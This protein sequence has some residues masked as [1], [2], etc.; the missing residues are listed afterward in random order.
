[1]SIQ[2]ALRVGPVAR[3]SVGLVALVVS[4]FVAMDLL[5]GVIPDR[6]SAQRQTRQRFAETLTVQVASLIEAGDERTLNRTLQQVVSRSP[7]VLS[8]AVRPVQGFIV[9][10]RGDHARN[11]ISPESGRSTLDHVRVP[12][13]GQRERW[14]DV[15]FAFAH[16]SP[17]GFQE[18][19]GDPKLLLVGA[20]SVGGFLLFYPY[21]RRALHFLDPS[22]AVPDRVRGA[23]DALSAGVIVVDSGGRIVLAN[24]SV[25]R[26]HPEGGAELHGS[27]FSELPWLRAAEKGDPNA[28]I[29]WDRAFRE[30]KAVPRHSLSIA[31]PDNQNIEVI[32]GC[33]PIGDDKG[34]VRGSLVTFDDVT[35]IYRTNEQLRSTLVDLERSREKIQAQNEELQRLAT[36]DPLTGC[37]NRRAFFENAGI[38]FEDR[39]RTNQDLSCIMADIDHFKNFNDLYGHAV[40]DQVI[41]VV[42]RT[43]SRLMRAQ[44]L[45]CRY[46][47]EEFCIVLPDADLKQAAEI[48]ERLRSTIE[49]GA[50]SAIRSTRV[51]R[52]TSSFG[53]ASLSQGSTRLEQLID[54]ADNALYRSK[55][56]GRNRVTPWQP[57][58]M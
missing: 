49:T 48:A 39:L 29:G 35:E 50:L 11:W 4:L 53:V 27:K 36:R 30:G 7:D 20:L 33:S 38:L 44:D 17:R 45:L 6:E 34:R 25:R 57:R 32:V 15:E 3:L 52:V 18:W 12:I 46:G 23:F 26:L 41:Q 55:E 21:L 31:Q 5:F 37:L 43:L 10:Q 28:A 54:Q 58:E 14:G 16:A 42:A 9:A 47:G 51:E 8:I 56:A 22:T 1:M 40:G 2:A 24:R 19:V 13:L